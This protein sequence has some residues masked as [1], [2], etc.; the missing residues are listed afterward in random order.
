MKK[1][2]FNHLSH[3]ISRYA[4]SKNFILEVELMR[5]GLLIKEFKVILECKL[6]T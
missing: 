6:N 3:S 5:S 1:M 2:I 4:S